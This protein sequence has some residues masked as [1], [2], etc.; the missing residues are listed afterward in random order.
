MNEENLPNISSSMVEVSTTNKSNEFVVVASQP[1]QNEI[2]SLS[3]FSNI[4]SKFRK[5]KCKMKRCYHKL[6]GWQMQTQEIIST[7]NEVRLKRK[8]N[9]KTLHKTPIKNKSKLDYNLYSK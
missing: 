8:F 5:T 3:I 7:I 6:I 4:L 9:S 2:N 1:A